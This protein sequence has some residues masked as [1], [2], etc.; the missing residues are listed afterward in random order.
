MTVVPR[1][2][3]AMGLGLGRAKGIRDFLK[4]YGNTTDDNDGD[5]VCVTMI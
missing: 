4:R 2:V 5:L 1:F 3:P